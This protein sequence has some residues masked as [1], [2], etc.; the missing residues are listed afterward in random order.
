MTVSFSS[1][2]LATAEITDSANGSAGITLV[3]DGQTDSKDKEKVLPPTNSENHSENPSLHQKPA[4][5]Y[6]ATGEHT[7]KRPLLIGLSLLLVVILVVILKKYSS[8]K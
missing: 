4:G 3:D 1:P 8:K 2:S 7:T 6:P 5:R